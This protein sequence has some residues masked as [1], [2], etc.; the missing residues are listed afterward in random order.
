MFRN[1][2]SVLHRRLY[3]IVFVRV[4]E[5][6]TRIPILVGRWVNHQMLN[7]FLLMVTWEC[8]ASVVSRCVFSWGKFGNL[9]TVSLLFLFD[10]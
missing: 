5:I 1:I 9:Y 7:V 3:Y 2:V 10:N 6:E 4:V 8:D